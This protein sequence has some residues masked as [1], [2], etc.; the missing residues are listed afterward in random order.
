MISSFFTTMWYQTEGCAKHYHFASAI[1][2]LSFV[3]LE[4]CIII[5][6]AVG[7]SGHGKDVVYD[8]NVRNKLM[9]K[10]SM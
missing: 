6:I 8:M 4:F 1:Y 2:L 9:L 5:D 10:L 3:A 7:S